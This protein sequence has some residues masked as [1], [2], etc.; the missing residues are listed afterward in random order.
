MILFTG[1]LI[2]TLFISVMF[3]QDECYVLLSRIGVTYTGSCKKGLADG[4]G[5]AIGIDHYKGEFK[6]G[7]PDG[8]GTYKWQTGETYVGEWTKGLRNGQGKYTFKYRDRDSTLAGRWKDDKYIGVEALPPY[9]IEYKNGIGRISCMRVGDRPYV[10]FAFS[11]SGI[12][13]LLMQASSGSETMTDSFIGYEQAEFPFKSIIKFSAPNAWMT[14]MIYCELR[15]TINQPGAW[16]IT[17][18]F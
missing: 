5:E 14:A 7:Y 6:K 8:Q 4:Q 15:L 9:I 1:I 2:M 11:R 13:G 10:R 17:M 12:S 18:S 16:M 3:G